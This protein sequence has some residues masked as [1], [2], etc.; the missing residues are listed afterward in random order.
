MTTTASKSKPVWEAEVRWGRRYYT[1]EEQVP[2]DDAEETADGTVTEAPEMT[3]VKVQHSIAACFVD[4]S[5]PGCDRISFLV[6]HRDGRDITFTDPR[7]RNM[8]TAGVTGIWGTR[9]A[10]P[11]VKPRPLSISA[12]RIEAARLIGAERADEIIRTLSA[13]GFF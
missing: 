9:P 10:P 1:T 5:R 2:S 8:G 11:V 4:F 12:F 3:T 6:N 7:V 13:P